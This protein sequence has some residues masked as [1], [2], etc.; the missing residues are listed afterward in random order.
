MALQSHWVVFVCSKVC[1]L[2]KTQTEIHTQGL[3]SSKGNAQRAQQGQ[4]D[5]TH[6]RRPWLRDPSAR[7]GRAD[8]RPRGE[9]LEGIKC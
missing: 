6:L 8:L 1:A 5:C 9:E 2:G 4:E 3:T 7:Q